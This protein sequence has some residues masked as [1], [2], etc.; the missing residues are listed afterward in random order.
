MMRKH[1]CTSA[2]AGLIALAAGGALAQ[3]NQ[4]LIDALVR[5]GILTQKEDEKIQREVLKNP[6]VLEQSPIKLAPWIK[7]LKLGGDL[8][9][10]YQYDR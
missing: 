7:E 3:D 2:L 9:L 6:A 4:A 10:R 5:K 8:Q 1:I